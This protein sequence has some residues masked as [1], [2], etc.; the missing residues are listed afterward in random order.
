MLPLANSP[1]ISVGYFYLEPRI[2]QL[3]VADPGCVA[4]TLFEDIFVGG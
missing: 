1:L 2:D 3:E 4:Y